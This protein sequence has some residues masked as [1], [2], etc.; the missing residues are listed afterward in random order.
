MHR[1]RLWGIE[2]REGRRQNKKGENIEETRGNKARL[3][4][5]SLETWRLRKIKARGSCGDSRGSRRVDAERGDG[6]PELPTA[7]CSFDVA[8]STRISGR[9]TTSRSPARKG[10][11]QVELQQPLADA[12]LLPDERT[13]GS[14]RGSGH[15]VGKGG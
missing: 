8:G 12:L 1:Q 6:G 5:S 2:V 7:S 11:L 13:K 14:G 9:L 3:T 10:P 15:G 4:L